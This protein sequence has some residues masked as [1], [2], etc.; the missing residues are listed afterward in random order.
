VYVGGFL[1]PASLSTLSSPVP[2]LSWWNWGF[3]PPQSYNTAKNLCM[4]QQVGSQPLSSWGQGRS[5]DLHCGLCHVLP[6]VSGGGEKAGSFTSQ[7]SEKHCCVL[8]WD[9][10]E[11][12]SIFPLQ[13][14]EAPLPSQSIE[15][16]FQLSP[17][18]CLLGWGGR[19]VR[20]WAAGAKVGTC[21][22]GSISPCFRARIRDGY[23]PSRCQWGVGG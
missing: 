8:V 22:L 20:T 21:G 16:A 12:R 7:S 9:Q 15:A 14:R 10:S 13:S 17:K 23:C 3:T 2:S 4:C 11:N 6:L 18:L 19:E 5:S 1:T